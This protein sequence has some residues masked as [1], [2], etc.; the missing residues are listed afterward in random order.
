ML[1]NHSGGALTR[2][3]SISI[4]FAIPACPSNMNRQSSA[5]TTVGMAQGTRIAARTSAAA[6]EGAVHGQREDAAQAELEGDARDGEQRAVC[7]SAFQNR[8]IPSAS[9]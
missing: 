9:A 6:A 8:A 1:T 5:A 3:S 7:D 2:P 4:A